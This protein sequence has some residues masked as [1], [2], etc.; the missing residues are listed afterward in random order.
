MSGLGPSVPRL[1]ILNLCTL[2]GNEYL[3]DDL[4]SET[5]MS[6]AIAHLGVQH[7]IVMGEFVSLLNA[8]F[9]A[10]DP[11]AL[12]V[13]RSAALYVRQSPVRARRF[14]QTWMRLALTCASLSR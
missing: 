14:S 9:E 5:V 1:P 12:Q 13:T 11:F 7:I 6:Y 8:L 10:N 2:A 3:V 4:S